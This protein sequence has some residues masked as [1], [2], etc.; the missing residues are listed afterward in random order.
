MSEDGVERC[1]ICD[2]PLDGETT[3]TS[4]GV[5]HEE[6]AGYDDGAD[7]LPD[8]GTERPDPFEGHRL[9]D[10]EVTSNL[11]D[12]A[13]ID[14][15]GT[16]LKIFQQN[17]HV[18]VLAEIWVE[19]ESQ[20]LGTINTATG[21]TVALGGVEEGLADRVDEISERPVEEIPGALEEL[22]YRLNPAGREKP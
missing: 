17:E 12:G 11:A 22:A 7:V 6:C 20:P 3:T 2:E 16:T 1:P 14:I 5:A 13:T 21:E 19:D 8:G 18:P 15:N 4:E 9:M 10:V